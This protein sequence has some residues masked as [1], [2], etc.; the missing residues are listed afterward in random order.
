MKCPCKE[1]EFMLGNKALSR[2][3]C[4]AKRS[5]FRRR[6]RVPF[7]LQYRCYSRQSVSVRP[8]DRQQGF[9][10]GFAFFSCRR[11]LASE[12]KVA[13]DE[14]RCTWY[15]YMLVRA[16]RYPKVSRSNSTRS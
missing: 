1:L 8:G 6:F 11:C 4:D 12:L 5:C 2:T 16:N 3:H 13:A 7:L 10:I 15:N 9:S 14:I